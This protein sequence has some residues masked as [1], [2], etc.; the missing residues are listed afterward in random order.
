MIQ[1]D[2]P[3]WAETLR[4]LALALDSEKVIY[5]Y[6]LIIDFCQFFFYNPVNE[7]EEL[8]FDSL[9]NSMV[10]V[11]PTTAIALAFAK[12]WFLNRNRTGAPLNSSEVDMDTD[13]SSTENDSSVTNHNLTLK[14]AVGTV[15]KV[16][17]DTTIGLGI[18]KLLTAPR[19]SAW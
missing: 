6:Y 1:V 18:G 19:S 4:G 16:A 11:M 10:V 7:F 2:E 9:L 5:F 14:T 12:G 3:R 17:Y 15:L 8:G 13:N